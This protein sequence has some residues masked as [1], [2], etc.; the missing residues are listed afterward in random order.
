MSRVVSSRIGL[1]TIGVVLLGGPLSTDAF[2]VRQMGGSA[3]DERPN[4][5][6]S[7]PA[8]GDDL[9]AELEPVA[10]GGGGG[11]TC[12]GSSLP[13]CSPTTTGPS[14]AY[15]CD[16]GSACSFRYYCHGDDRIAG[17]A[18][19]RSR[20]FALSPSATPTAAAAALE[21]WATQREVDLG[22]P[23]GLTTTLLQFAPANNAKVTQGVLNLYRVRQF[24]R[25]SAALP[26]LPVMGDGSLLTLEASPVGVVALKGTI[27]D[28]RRAYAF[29]ASQ[30][31]SAKAIAS[32][33]QHTST[34]LGIP[35]AQISVNAPV[36]VAVP[37]V[38]Q[39][40]W[41]GVA[42]RGG[43]QLAR[44]TVSA[45]P[46]P[47]T[48]PLLHF[49]SGVVEGLADTVP[50][51]LRTQDPA[52]DPFLEPFMELDVDE[53]ADGTTV[54]GSIDD[55]TGDTQL[56]DSSVVLVDV[57]SGTSDNLVTGNLSRYTSATDTFPVS[58]P[59]DYFYAQRMFYLLRS[60]YAIV[61]RI[62]VGKW[63][64][65]LQHYGPGMSSGYAAGTFA[66]RMIALFNHAGGL[67]AA[68]KHESYGIANPTDLGLLLGAFPEIVQRPSPA[69]TPEVVSTMLLPD[70]S[71]GVDI[72]FHEVGHGFDVF[73]GPG[74]AREYAPDCQLGSPGCDE[75]C[76]EDTTD[77]AWPLDETVAQLI[78]LWMVRRT[79]PE[80]PHAQCDLLDKY[81]AGGTEN[82]QQVHSPECLNPGD[83]LNIWLRDDDPG[84]TDNTLCDKP[85]RQAAPGYGYPNNCRTTDG[86]NTFS[87]LQAWWNALN[88]KYC[89]PT[90]PFDCIDYAPQ[91]PPGC[92]GGG[93]SPECVT[94]DEAAGL[95]LIYALRTNA[96][97]YVEFF[98]AMSRFVACNYGND[99]Y[100]V[101]N[102]AL[103]D[104][105]IRPCNAPLPLVCETC[106]NGIREGGENC[107]GQDLTVDEVGIV[108]QCIDFGYVGGDL[109]CDAMCAL[110]FSAC[111]LPPTDTSAGGETSGDEIGSAG[112][113]TGSGDGGQVGEDGCSCNSGRSEGQHA[114]LLALALGVDPNLSQAAAWL[115]QV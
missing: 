80:L 55:F 82:L 32:I 40:G 84:C 19:V 106:G 17:M 73:L 98:D 6:V 1:S 9:Q 20:L 29:S 86:Y 47:A 16:T 46:V 72:L 99:A 3:G 15:P 66:P 70:K 115:A 21:T 54:L 27:I 35:V 58:Q 30:A 68:A 61:D 93:G 92:G 105:G 69:D 39:I 107:D 59:S 14:C 52:S 67:G 63:D 78:S 94:A 91:W 33:K 64:S 96:L 88:G 13:T 48:L 37:R 36:R 41:Y 114:G 83:Q 97:S 11:T 31:T 45:N 22:V 34:R 81:S 111:E 51:E 90:A 102:T 57:Q 50:I 104:H 49:D 112:E 77:E 26:S 53:L 8:T 38:E 65:P 76:D 42:Y 71:V 24:Y 89:Q 74:N 100:L 18:V 28:P 10:S 101:F 2:A 4:S 75:V 109:A 95:A 62:A 110:D 25:A 103:C 108:P 44:V 85:Y 56:A 7:N 43:D 79:F 23:N 60:A 87:V 113:S 5:D 12:A